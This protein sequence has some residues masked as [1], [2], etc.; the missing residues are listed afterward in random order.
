[1][2][3]VEGNIGVG[4]S[5][6]LNLIQEHCPDIRAIQEPIQSW[7]QQTHDGQSLLDEF[8]KDPKRWAYTIET[9]AM[10]RRSKDHIRYQE[11]PNPNKI[12]ERSVYSGHFCFAVNGYKHGYLNA[13]EWNIYNKWADFLLK[14]RCK[15]PSGFIYLRANPEVCMSRVK[16]RSRNSETNLSLDYLKQIHEQHEDFLINKNVFEELKDV[17]VLILDCNKDMALEKDTFKS[18][19]KDVQNF[20][21]EAKQ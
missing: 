11:D 2:Y 15:K 18:Y 10:I 19:I 21:N 6:F 14:K 17:P 4:K 16:K 8:Y 13:V 12:M 1:M 3:I 7:D 9:L 5:T 20:I